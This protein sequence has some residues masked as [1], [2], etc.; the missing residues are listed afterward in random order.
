[1]YS[2][3]LDRDRAPPPAPPGAPDLESHRSVFT[4]LVMNRSPLVL[5]KGQI[6][7]TGGLIS[8]RRAPSA[9]EV[10]VG[11]AACR[12]PWSRRRSPGG[13]GSVG[14]RALIWG[15]LQSHLCFSAFPP[16]SPP[17]FPALTPPRRATLRLRMMSPRRP[18]QGECDT[19]PDS[20]WVPPVPTNVP[21]RAPQG[22]A[23]CRSCGAVQTGRWPRGPGERVLQA[24]RSSAGG[25]VK[26][27]TLTV[28]FQS[29]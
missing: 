13:P 4:P 8:D 5:L 20:G 26:P 12:A 15:P 7:L 22:A 16:C 21:L 11:T 1:M 9:T 3:R 19:V 17:T 2:R 23:Q 25:V 27:E 18:I 29:R 28:Q 10:G 6:R 24:P 14:L